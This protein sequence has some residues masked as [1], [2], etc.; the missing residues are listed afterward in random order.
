[1]PVE[2]QEAKPWGTL[3][4]LLASCLATLSAVAA[5][6]DPDVVLLR[7]LQA[8]LGVAAL[9]TICRLVFTTLLAVT[10]R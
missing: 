6:V 7:A 1:M 3:L 5:G 10:K 2:G 9:W 4:G 8:G